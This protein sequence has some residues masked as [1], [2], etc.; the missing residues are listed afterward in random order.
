MAANICRAERLREATEH[1]PEEI[2]REGN[3][4]TRESGGTRYGFHNHAGRINDPTGQQGEGSATRGRA[5]IG[6]QQ[7]LHRTKQLDC[8]GQPGC[9]RLE[10]ASRQ[11][12]GRD[13]GGQS[14]RCRRLG[15]IMQDTPQDGSSSGRF[16]I[17]PHQPRPAAG[18]YE[19]NL[20]ART[21]GLQS[22]CLD[23]CNSTSEA[24]L[25]PSPWRMATRPGCTF[26][27][28]AG[29]AGPLCAGGR[30]DPPAP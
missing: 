15:Q 4:R 1:K 9:R 24:A 26:A 7:P 2:G 17:P 27:Q 23:L 12:E 14:R 3:R 5:T 6:L 19:K 13:L 10:I 28:A 18:P 11:F 21:N 16:A 8:R 29:K 30:V 20:P 22:S 25:A